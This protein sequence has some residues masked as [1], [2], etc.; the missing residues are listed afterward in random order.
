MEP[1]LRNETLHIHHDILHARIVLGEARA[2]DVVAHGL[3]IECD[4]GIPAR[5]IIEVRGGY[6]EGYRG[7]NISEQYRY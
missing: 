4:S 2:Q 7:M 1:T 6:L 5:R 3:A